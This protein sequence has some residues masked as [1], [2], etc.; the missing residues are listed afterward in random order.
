MPFLP[1]R[2]DPA[3]LHAFYLLEVSVARLPAQ[4]D[5]DSAA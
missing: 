1:G 4:V 3:P 5:L 2:E